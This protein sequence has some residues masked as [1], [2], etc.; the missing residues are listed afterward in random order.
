MGALGVTAILAGC[1]V[2]SPEPTDLSGSMGT[3]NIAW[4][5]NDNGWVAGSGVV[6]HDGKRTVLGT[7]GGVE[8]TAFAINNR[9]WI[10]GDSQTSAGYFHATLWQG[11]K[12]TDLGTLGGQTSYAIAINS[13]GW[14]VGLSKTPSGPR[15]GF[16]WHD[17]TMTD[18]TALTGTDFEPTGIS[19][20]GTISGHHSSSNQPF[21]GGTPAI[22]N[23]STVTDLPLRPA[24]GSTSTFG[25]AQAINSQGDVAGFMQGALVSPAIHTQ[26][27]VIWK[28]DGTIT[29]I[30]NLPTGDY[31]IAARAI[32][33]SDQVVW[34]ILTPGPEGAIAEVASE[35]SNHILNPSCAPPACIN[36][37]G[38]AAYVF[39]INNHGTVVGRAEKSVTSGTRGP[40][41]P[42]LWTPSGSLTDLAKK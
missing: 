13:N 15:H 37:G 7:L 3:T 17:G 11:S 6:L 5:I 29:E 24:D 23:G 25:D 27:L 40:T 20:T 34:Q 36:K 22:L 1:M 19:D 16:L 18:L 32:N 42:A 31:G 35:G 21:F 2:W 30:A 8:A 33:N 39:G 38:R 9:N 4:A 28:H 41:F 14:V 12:V 10:V 26:H